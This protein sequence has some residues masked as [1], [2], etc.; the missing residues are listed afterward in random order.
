MTFSSFHSC[1]RDKPTDSGTDANLSLFHIQNTAY[2]SRDKCRHVVSFHSVY[3]SY[4]SPR[5]AF[6]T[7]DMTDDIVVVI[8]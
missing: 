2:K 5:E 4:N 3:L 8:I 1:T 7:K 6:I